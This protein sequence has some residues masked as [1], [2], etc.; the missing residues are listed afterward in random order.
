MT[1]ESEL[2]P[3]SPVNASDES[4]PTEQTETQSAV[5]EVTDETPL[6]AGQ[7]A[8]CPPKGKKS[9]KRKIQQQPDAPGGNI[10]TSKGVETMFRS[11]FRTE[12]ELLALAAT[13]ANIMISLNG[14]I[15][16]A[17]MVSGAFLF[18][19]S[20]EFLI[21]ATI[22]MVTAA[23]SIVFALLSASPDR[24]GR[25]RETWSWLCD[26]VRRRAAW[27]DFGTRVLN[28]PRSRFFGDSPN[29]L[30]YEDRAKIPKEKYWEMMQHLMANREQVYYRMSEELYWLGLMANK[31]FKYLNMSYTAFRWGLLTSVVAFVSIKTLPGL[32]PAMQ[33]EQ[34]AAQLQPLGI[35]LFKGIYEPS[36]VQQLPDGRILIVEDEPARA[37]NIVTASSDGG[38]YENDSLDE[39]ITRG[40][41]RKLSD[42]E[43]LT[44]DPHGNIYAITSHSVNRSGQRRPDREHLLRF[45]IT[46]SEVQSLKVYDGLI[47]TLQHSAEWKN[48]IR[49]KAGEPFDARNTNIEGLAFDPRNNLLML[50]FRAPKFHHQDLVAYIDNPDDVFE[51]GIPPHFISVALL[52][53][54]GGGIRSMNYDPVLKSFVISN[55][56][57]DSSGIKHSQLWK[58]SGRPTDQAQRIEVPNLNYIANVEAVDS[59]LIDG[60]PRLLLMGDEGNAKENRPAK[61]MLVDYDHLG[62]P[63][64]PTQH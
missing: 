7:Q 58:W 16:S 26:V 54:K 11:A 9:K 30:I 63:P 27:R 4:S 48:L 6:P 37:A 29:I 14:F 8:A 62:T 34:Q 24:I 35:H 40:L 5:S 1:N 3:R 22:F 53:L 33:A 52:D 25:L 59:V 61:Y 38:L 32:L 31:Q 19:S 56:F 15:V 42:L 23:A 57:K 44:R 20:P 43:G 50:G 12:M 46:D 18:S 47:D 17:L 36:A 55:E 64:A 13:K 51:K 21:P 28:N 45:R 60:K 39:Q 10:G 2:T 41:G 49:D